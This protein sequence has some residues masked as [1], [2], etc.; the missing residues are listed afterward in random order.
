MGGKRSASQIESDY[1]EEGSGNQLQRRKEGIE[2]CEG[3]LEKRG[4]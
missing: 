2:K 3:A 4:N 1:L